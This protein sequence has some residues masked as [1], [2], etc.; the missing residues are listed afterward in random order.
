MFALLHGIATV[1]ATCPALSTLGDLN[2]T[3]FTAKTWYIQE[4]QVTKY[5]ERNTFYCTAATYN[6]EGKKVPFFDGKVVSVYNYAN[7]DKINGPNENANNMTLCA[8]AVNETD[9]SRLAVAPCFLPNKFA[10]DYWVIDHADDYSWSIVIGG[11]PTEQ[12]ADGCTTKE[13]GVNNAGLWL[14]SR[15]PVAS[16][17]SIQLMR[18]RLEKMGIAR[19]RLFPVQQDGCVYKDAVIKR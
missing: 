13:T 8:R 11:Q 19:S 5:L 3:E 4:M 10:G 16:K 2:L 15:S 18:D 14:F 6:F 17:S 7:L 9:A 12:Y 1:I